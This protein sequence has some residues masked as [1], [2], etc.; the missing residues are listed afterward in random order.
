VKPRHYQTSGGTV[1]YCTHRRVPYPH[2]SSVC[3]LRVVH[4]G[5]WPD[6]QTREPVTCRKCI[7][8][9][10]RPPVGLTAPADGDSP[11]AGATSVQSDG[12]GAV[13]AASSPA[14]S[15]E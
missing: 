3:G 11:A 15:E 13:R 4:H 7:D 10:D 5:A 8:S 14:V 1:H 6:V 9:S 2:Y 12:R